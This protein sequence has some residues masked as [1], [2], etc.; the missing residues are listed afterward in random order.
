MAFYVN[1]DTSP[2][3]LFVLDLATMKPLQLTSAL[4]PKIRSQDLV[5][6]E[7]VRY[8]S[9]DGLDVPAILYR[10][11]AASPTAKVPALVWVHGGPGGQSRHGY[12][13]DIQHLVNHGYAIL[14][15]NNR[16]SSGYGKKFFHLDDRNHGEGDLQDCIFGRKYLAGLDWI[17]AAKVGIIGGSYGGYMVTAALALTPDAFEAGVDIFGVTN[18]LRTLQSIPPWWAAF[19]DSLYAEMGDP[20]TDEPRLRKISSL[21]HAHNIVKPLMVV[22]GKNDPRVLQVESDEIV[23]AAKKNGAPVEYIVFPDEGHGFIRKEN[24]VT[25]AAGIVKFLDTHL[26]GAK[27]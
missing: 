21:F 12:N 25:S 3:N 7:V 26:K 5:E 6:G 22:Q 24:R 19:R 14:A 18:W 17:D 27:Q 15:V 11:W 23:A 8:E 13:A 20:A 4:N 9:F 16:G 1:G 10:P 2:A